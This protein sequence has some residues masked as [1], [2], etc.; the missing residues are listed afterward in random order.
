MLFS[1]ALILLCGMFL[2]WL[3][4]KNQLPS[5]VGMIATGI[6]LGPYMLGWIDDSLLNISGEIRK[7]ALIIILMRAGLTLKAKDLKKVGRPA[8]LMCF[9]P[10][11]F[12]ILGM[13][14]IAPRFFPISMI[15]AAVMGA[16]VAAVSPA[17][18]VPKMIR[19]TEEGY[20][21]KRGI[22]Q[23][24]LAGAS[25][26]DVFVIVLFTVFCEFAKGEQVS[27]WQF[28]D[29]PISILFGVFIG[30]LLGWLLT[31]YF[32]KVH[33]RDTIK[34]IIMLCLAFF[35]VTAEDKL[36]EKIP[37]SG[38]LAIMGMGITLR[39]KKKQIADR[40][41]V[42]FNKLWIGAEIMLFVL[43]GATLD[44]NYV[45]HAGIWSVLL[46]VIV[47]I[48]RIIGV[49]LCLIKTDFT[50]KERIFCG[51]AYMPKATVQAAIGGIPLTMGLECGNLVLTIAVLA[52]LITAP[53]GAFL[54]EK[55]YWRLLTKN[56][57]IE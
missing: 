26:D 52:V 12:E 15:E 17:V 2:G 56:Q 14:F 1:I 33:I 4:K 42:K 34:V 45:I 13:V 20:G 57:E 48:F 54:I 23:L 10:A 5:L 18:I 35:L 37:F 7:I 32:E 28:L 43:V 30:I 51:F 44:L 53:L 29:I 36:A 19:L 21:T 16:V 25:V 40:L 22:P 49:F 55:S 9:V 38:L 39:F 3:C 6:L 50:L 11:C 27:F 46:I 31:V 41:S 24:I 47:L 8:F